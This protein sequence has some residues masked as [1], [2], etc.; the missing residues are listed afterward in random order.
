M[1]PLSDQVTPLLAEEPRALSLE[2]QR[3]K[4]GAS[5]DSKNTLDD[6]TIGTETPGSWRTRV[7]ETKHIRDVLAPAS[8]LGSDTHHKSPV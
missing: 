6:T 4:C 5:K 1:N 8:F 2:A 3:R 7:P